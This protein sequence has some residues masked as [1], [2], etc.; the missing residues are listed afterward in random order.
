[1]RTTRSF[2]SIFAASLATIATASTERLGKDQ[3]ALAQ[4]KLD[5]AGCILT[6]ETTVIIPGTEAGGLV[7]PILAFQEGYKSCTSDWNCV[8]GSNYTTDAEENCVEGGGNM[9]YED[10][11][12][13]QTILDIMDISTDE[14]LPIITDVPICLAQTCPD[15]TTYAEIMTEMNICS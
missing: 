1:M 6:T 9:I 5:V 2:I 4:R 8:L 3:R 15:N 12:L 11:V 7:G 10:V 14:I 13:C